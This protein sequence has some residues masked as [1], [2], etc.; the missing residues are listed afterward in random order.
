MGLEFSKSGDVDIEIPADV[1]AVDEAF[2]VKDVSETLVWLYR[3]GV[4]IVV[5]T[6]DVSAT[7]K[8]FS[9]VR[10]MMPWAT[11]IKKCTAVCTVCGSDA[12]YTHKKVVSEK[13]IEVGGMDAYEPRCMAHHGAIRL[14]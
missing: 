5:S 12:H 3:T 7:G 4:S 1:V 14:L 9:E 6:L 10:D 2:M 11:R 13:E 8:V